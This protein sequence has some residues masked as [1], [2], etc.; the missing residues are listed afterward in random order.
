[1]TFEGSSTQKNGFCESQ[2][3]NWK[4]RDFFT[5]SVTFKT[6]SN[7]NYM[8]ELYGLKAHCQL[9]FINPNVKQKIWNILSWRWC[10][11]FYQE[12]HF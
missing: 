8:K 12:K 3:G 10:L 9:E 11:I 7:S 6:N 4:I 5:I 1:M 2:K